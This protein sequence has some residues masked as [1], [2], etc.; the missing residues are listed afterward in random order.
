MTFTFT[1]APADWGRI[2]PELVLV[3]MTLLVMI[4]DILLPQAG[5]RSQA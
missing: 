3:G 4:V 5:E 1:V 2:A